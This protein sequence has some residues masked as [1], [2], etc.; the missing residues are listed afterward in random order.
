MKNVPGKISFAL[1]A[2]TSPNI[3]GFLGITCH[4]ID[5]NWK[6]RDILLDFVYLEGSH[7]GENLAN[8]FLKCLEEKKIF[9]KVKYILI[10]IMYY[11]DKIKILMMIL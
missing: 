5:A 1:D 10:Y 3:L 8:A 11:K 9:T 4:Y 2:W 7:S 6:L